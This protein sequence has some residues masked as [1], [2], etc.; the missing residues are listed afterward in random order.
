LEKLHSEILEQSSYS[1]DFAPSNYHPFESLET[2]SKGR[3][4]SSNEQ[5]KN[6]VH[7]WFISQ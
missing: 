7:A 1:S 6:G 5:L 3:R 2:A 4:F